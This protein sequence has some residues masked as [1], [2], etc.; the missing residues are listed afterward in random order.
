MQQLELFPSPKIRSPTHGRTP[1]QELA[2][3]QILAA[4]RQEVAEL[5]E[6]E[7]VIDGELVA[8]LEPRGTHLRIG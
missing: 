7:L 8:K 1:E 5:G 4:R 3:Q 6:E 2:F